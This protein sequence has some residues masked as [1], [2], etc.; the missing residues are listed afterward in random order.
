MAEIEEREVY[1]VPQ[2]GTLVSLSAAGQVA[3]ALSDVRDLEA[4]LRDAKRILTDALVSEAVARGTKTIHLDNVTVE[5]RGGSEVVWD[6]QDLEA[7]LLSAGAPQSLVDEIISTEITYKVDARRASRA[8]GANPVYA[9]VV[10]RA[11][12]EVEKPHS[13][14]LR[15][16][17]RMMEREGL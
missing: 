15:K 12:N 16:G 1:L 17:A 6:V 9:E 4:Q 11:R 2:L 3:Q 7:G 8:A 5:I 14:V 10:E 13:V